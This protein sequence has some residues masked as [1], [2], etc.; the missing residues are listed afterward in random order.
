MFPPSLDRKLVALVSD[1]VKW[2]WR[3]GG[4]VRVQ[5][6]AAWVGGGGDGEME[7]EEKE[8]S[9][10]RRADSDRAG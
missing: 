8:V 9:S 3:K 7:E 2:S 6:R 10:G 4:A 1:E 5:R